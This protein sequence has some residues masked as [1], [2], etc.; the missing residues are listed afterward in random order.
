MT[1]S[2]LDRLKELEAAATKGWRHSVG[3]DA[4]VVRTDGSYMNCGDAVYHQQFAADAELIAAMRNALPDLL[5]AA[6]ALAK[7]KAWVTARLHRIEG[8]RDKESNAER[9]A[10]NQVAALLTKAPSGAGR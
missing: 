10:L 9:I 8:S 1:A 6:D 4:R 3:M 7:V 5:A 2:D